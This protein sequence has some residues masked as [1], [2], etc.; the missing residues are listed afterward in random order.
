MLWMTNDMRRALLVMLAWWAVA[1][2]AVTFDCAKAANPDENAICSELPLAK[3]DGEFANGLK[4]VN[5]NLS[6]PMRAYLKAVQERWAAS[7]AAPR[8]GAC[9]GAVPCITGK[10]RDR[11]AYLR[12]PHLPYEG[13]Y[14]AKKVKFSLESFASGALRYGFYP[15]DGGAPLYFNEGATPRIANREL[16]PPP[17]ADQCA[18]RLEFGQDGNLNVYLKEARKKACHKFKLVAGTYARDYAQLPVN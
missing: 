11:L 15:H 14:A 16:L 6:L 9:Q 10:Y 1:A 3:L 5:A 12:N 4:V 2:H 13:V 18:L 7:T 8:S 17:P